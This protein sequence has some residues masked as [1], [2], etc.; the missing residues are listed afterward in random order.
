M[1]FRVDGA[2]MSNSNPSRE[3]LWRF[4]WFVAGAILGRASANPTGAAARA[5]PSRSEIDTILWS[6]GGIAQ[7]FDLAA[8]N[9]EMFMAAYNRAQ[10]HERR[11]WD[12]FTRRWPE[13]WDT[14]LSLRSGS[15]PG[16]PFAAQDGSFDV[17]A[18]LRYLRNAILKNSGAPVAVR[19]MAMAM[20]PAFLLAAPP[21]TGE[22]ALR[23]EKL[24]Q[25][26]SIRDVAAQVIEGYTSESFHRVREMARD[27]NISD[28]DEWKCFLA[29]ILEAGS[30]LLGLLTED[31]ITR[32]QAN[33]P[34]KSTWAPIALMWTN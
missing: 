34:R 8:R 24:M 7:V 19:T 33:D 6:V 29:D 22:R 26:A 31:A 25:H 17:A 14:V 1:T 4:V 21:P 15:K 2:A 27:M 16:A 3:W 12:V 9:P 32:W 5:R 10:E 23:L 11:R 20:D 30:P 18:T 28:V 13:A